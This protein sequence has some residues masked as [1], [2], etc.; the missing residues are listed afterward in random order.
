[1]QKKNV[2][3]R[4]G[5]LVQLV[6]VPSKIGIIVKQYNYGNTS[7]YTIMFCESKPFYWYA[8]NELIFL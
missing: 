5:D 7:S 1:M 6:Q 3:N 2:K 4:V 8:E